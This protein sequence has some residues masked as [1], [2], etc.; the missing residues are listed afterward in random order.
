MAREV[1]GGR[2]PRELS[3]VVKIN[4]W[5]AAESNS[6][7]SVF[8]QE[9]MDACS[10]SDGQVMGPPPFMPGLESK[11]EPILPLSWFRA[12]GRDEF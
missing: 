10:G 2:L 4:A 11:A 6:W 5:W 7:S 12:C 3:W 9:T 1:V 8:G